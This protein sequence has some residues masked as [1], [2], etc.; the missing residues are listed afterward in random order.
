MTDSKNI[1]FLN[2]F[3]I[4][5]YIIIGFM[6]HF[7]AVDRIA[8][9]FLYLS[10]LNGVVFLYL[11]K[12]KGLKGFFKNTFQN[13]IITILL[14]LF[15]GWSLLSLFYGVN[16]SEVIIESSRI[17]IYI[18]SFTNLFILLKSSKVSRNKVLL[19]FSI[20]LMVEVFWVF[21]IF[22]DSNYLNENDSIN[23]RRILDLRA[24]TGN[25]NITAFTMLLK[26][27]FLIFY[28][29]DRKS[30][31]VVF[32]I[33]IISFVC[34]TIFLLGSR[35][36]NLTLGLLTSGI[37][38]IG[39]KNTLISRKHAIV[40]LSAF[41]FSL[42]INGFIFQN[43]ESLNYFER[44]S[45]IVDT[46]SQK[47]I[48][49]YQHALQSIIK[50]P[51]L[52]I[53]L[54]NWKIY[55]IQ[56]DNAEINNYMIPY[57]VHNDFLEV[58]AELGI[59][60]FIL[61][62]GIYIFLFLSFIKFFRNKEII[63]S[64]KIFALTLIFGLFVYLCDSFLN[65]PFTRPV[66]QIPNL[67]IIAASFYLLTKNN[68]YLYKLDKFPYKG[69]LIYLFPFF[70]FV[71]FIGTTY[72]SYRVFNSFKKQNLLITEIGGTTSISS[73]DEIYDIDTQLPNVTVHTL[74]IAAI[75]ATLLLRKEKY[76]SILKYIDKGVQANPYIGYNEVVK[77]IYYLNKKLID[78][79]FKYAKKAYD[80]LPN[81]F[82]H[83]DHY[84]NL[85]EVKKDT[86]SLN[87]IYNDLKGNFME[88]K[89]RKYL[90]VSSR[91]KNN[92]GLSDKDLMEKLLVN[93]PTSFINK[94]YGIIGKIGRD[95][96]AK[97]Y[98]FQEQARAAFENK[99]FKKS[100]KLFDKARAI[101]PF[102]VSYFENAA[103]AY[104]K[105][106]E[107]QKSISILEKMIIDLKPKTG[108]AEYLLGINYLQ[109]E[110]NKLGC[111]YLQES[112]E[113]GFD[114]PQ[115]ILDQFCYKEKT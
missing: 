12:Q 34:F 57:H 60:G 3:L 68:I 71:L 92:I 90:Q 74:P 38:F 8:P 63:E 89:Y 69:F 7:N 96:A 98:I 10:I 50:H 43:N 105:I 51:L 72:V 19:L 107:N 87:K 115:A 80:I 56:S 91:M 13:N 16:S 26:T 94:A 100:A 58:A 73:L 103:N 24:F 28:L 14:Y 36:A 93:N 1:S 106:G 2:P 76:D 77:S 99:E 42:I 18:H 32:K 52:G 30:I 79:S 31:H 101:N 114:F 35:G 104:M 82:N 97:G 83:Y 61:Y 111:D 25:I 17:F 11:L 44:T 54:G 6:Y 88:E 23:S 20:I 27:P 102:E 5:L 29:F 37:C 21:K 9:Q 39:L 85:I 59:P 47:R 45:N 67:F 70:S 65:F 84:L 55:S 112:R 64:D 53:G 66:M 46:S 95:N 108:K 78:S 113:K 40:L 109:L 41:L 22:L 48:R 110:E 86:N 33:I 75:K 62:Y 15:W 4:I 49:Y 81:Q